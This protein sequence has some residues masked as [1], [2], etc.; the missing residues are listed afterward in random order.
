MRR[1]TF[2]AAVCAAA[3]TAGA[4][5]ASGAVVDQTVYECQGT[6]T[7]Q[8][9]ASFGEPD[10][11][12]RTLFAPDGACKKI[13]AGVEEDGNFSIDSFDTG[14]SAGVGRVNL[15]GADVSGV[16]AF[17][18]VTTNNNLPILKGP[19]AIVGDNLNATLTGADARPWTVT[20]IHTGDG[21][22]GV[23]CYR[24]KATWIGTYPS[25]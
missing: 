2:A 10:Y 20:E 25:G 23:R 17:I 24:T 4:S 8:V 5:T 11:A 7:W 3:L 13:H 1:A 15:I 12:D 19:V 9:S 14:D 21:S 6:G 16:D 22:C 18:G